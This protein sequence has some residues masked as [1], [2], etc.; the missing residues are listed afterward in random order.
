M[1]L[2]VLI[3]MIFVVPLTAFYVCGSECGSVVGL[4]GLEWVDALVQFDLRVG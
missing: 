2:V 4:L 1:M 3:V